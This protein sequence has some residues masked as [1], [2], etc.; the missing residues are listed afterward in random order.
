KTKTSSN[1]SSIKDMKFFL[2]NYPEFK[3]T[4]INLSKHML[5]STEIDKK[6]NQLE[7]LIGSGSLKLVDERRYVKE[8]SSLRKLKKDFGSTEQL[9]KSVDN[10]KL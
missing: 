7:D 4:S 6:I 2:E 5:L 3:K 8:I 10:D 9:Q 1:I